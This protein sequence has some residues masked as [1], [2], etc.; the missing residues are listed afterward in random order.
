MRSVAVHV[1]VRPNGD[2][3]VPCGGGVACGGSTFGFPVSVIEGSDQATATTAVL[4][5]LLSKFV[6]G[7]TSCTLMAYGQTGS[8]KTYTMF[9]PTGSLTEASL[10]QSAGRVPEL[11]GAFPV[12]MMELLSA[13]ELAGA[14]FHASAI[15]VYM[16]HAYD[17]L[18][19]R[20]PLKVGTS[21]GSGRGNL[22]VGDIGKGP[23]LS[24]DVVIVGG[25]HPSGCSCFHCFQ[26]TGGLV[27]KK[28]PAAAADGGRKPGVPRRS[29][30]PPSTS[31]AREGAAASGAG[32]GA[33][34]GGGGEFGTE[35][36]AL[37]PLR[38]PAD[39]A[40]LARL[41]ESERVAHSHALNDRSSRSHCLLRVQC[42]LV[43]EGGRARPRRFLFVDLAGSERIA[44][45]EVAGARLKEAANINQ[46]LTAL[47]RVVNEL[48][49]RR[50]HVSYRDAALTML[51]RASFDGPSCTAVVLNVS[52]DAGHA[53]ES[54]CSLRFGEKLAGVRTS[55]AAAQPT[56]VGAQRARVGAELR[57]ARARLAELARAG[58]G[59]YVRPDALPSEQRTL[60][61]N[62]ATLAQREAEARGL[63]AQLAEARAAGG[64]A[65]D[66]LAPRLEAARVQHAMIL[67]IV[68][69][70]KTIKALWHAG[71][72]AYERAE[73]QVAE[74]AA[75]MAVLG[76]EPEGGDGGGP[77]GR[78]TCRCASGGA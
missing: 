47:G 11:W 14:S 30:A 13:P 42:T 56:D 44:K 29:K 10:E 27:G 48:R 25:V 19:G 70:E 54:V 20:K 59:A 74:L 38:T 37:W 76:G 8:G 16:E 77:S 53:E 28:K 51:L 66:A 40:R 62:L 3:V 67:D 61:T 22:V 9:G 24:G 78:G 17:L 41:V 15:E 2:A 5:D 58:Q 71:T 39:V 49:E 35:G 1:R 21:K 45:T 34:A 36:E 26:K 23:M 68:E 32:A 57:A 18:D 50:P 60:R 63:T 31:G 6:S 12:A 52:G 7:G 46:S 55:A 4:S 69:K 75:Q 33:G 43:E 65:A 64:R 72:P 73:T